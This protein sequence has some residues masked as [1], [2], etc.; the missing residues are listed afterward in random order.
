[1]NFIVLVRFL[2]RPPTV[3]RLCMSRISWAESTFLIPLMAFA[4][5]EIARTSLAY[6]DIFVLELHGITESIAT[7]VFDV[8]FVRTIMFM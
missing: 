6:G 2:I 4:Q 7:R 3:D 5:S 8:A 1:M